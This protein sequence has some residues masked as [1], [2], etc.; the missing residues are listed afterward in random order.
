LGFDLTE[1]GNPPAPVTALAVKIDTSYL[2]LKKA[3]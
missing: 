1:L 3:A 2:F